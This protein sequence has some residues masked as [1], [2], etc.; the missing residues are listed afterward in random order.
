MYIKVQISGES[1]HAA[2]LNYSQSLLFGFIFSDHL[3]E[4]IRLIKIMFHRP[5]LP[6]R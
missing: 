5:R 3:A 2:G 4:R 1:Y 6:G